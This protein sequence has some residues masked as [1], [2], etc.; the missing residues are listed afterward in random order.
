M[1]GAADTG[2]PRGKVGGLPVSRSEWAS[3]RWTSSK[4]PPPGG[5]DHR[6]G[7]SG[8]TGTPGLH[9]LPRPPRASLPG[10]SEP[11]R[12]LHPVLPTAGGPEWSPPVRRAGGRGREGVPGS[13]FREPGP[14]RRCWRSHLSPAPPSPPRADPA[15]TSKGQRRPQAHAHG[16]RQRLPRAVDA[17]AVAQAD[18]EE[19]HPPH[20][21]RGPGSGG[22]HCQPRPP[23][24]PPSSECSLGPPRPRPPAATPPVTPPRPPGPSPS[25]G[26]PLPSP[27]P[28][29]PRP[30]PAGLAAGH[31]PSPPAGPQPH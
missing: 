2:D 19:L 3:A 24:D 17:A 7:K 5:G 9:A 20:A 28:I 31:S 29:L 6:K 25:P 26:P 23:A 27:P 8:R 4:P 22:V 15:P 1:R 11:P 10:K 16:S 13:R 18:L 14:C 21:A 12:Q 30:L